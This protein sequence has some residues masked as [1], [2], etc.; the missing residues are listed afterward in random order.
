MLKVFATLV[1]YMEITII[2]RLAGHRGE[3]DYGLTERLYLH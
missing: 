3:W 1:H 2:G